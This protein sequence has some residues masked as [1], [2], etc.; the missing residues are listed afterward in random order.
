MP[1]PSPPRGATRRAR[2][3][4]ARGSRQTGPGGGGAPAPPVP[5][6][7]A[8]PPRRSWALLAL[9]AAAAVL[10]YSLPRW[11]APHPWSYDEYYHLGV[12]R[13]LVRH[14]PLRRFPW[15]PFSILADHYA[16]KEILFHL[17]LMPFAR[18]PLAAAGIAGTL[19]GQVFVVASFAFALVRLGVPRPHR[20]VWGLALLGPLF[21]YRFAMC[22]PQVWMIA[23]ALLFLALLLGRARG[24]ALALAAALFG[25]AHTG[26]WI[27]VAFAAL[28]GLA[29]FLTP[30]RSAAASN[31]DAATRR[32]LWRPLAWTAGGWLAGQLVHPNFPA[33]FRLAFLQNVVVP[34]QSTG[35]GNAALGAVTGA[36]LTAPGLAVL[37]EQWPAFLAPIA[38]WVLL[39]REPRLRTR[40]TLT[41]AILAAGFLALGAVFFQRLLEIGAPLGLLAFALAVAERE[42]QAPPPRRPAAGWG[43][44]AAAGAVL[45][46]GLWSFALVRAHGFGVSYPLEMARWLGANGRSGERVFTAQWGDSA[47]IFYAAPQLQSLVALDPVF[48]YAKDRGLFLAYVDLAMGRS[49]DP[50]PAIARRFGCRWVTV[51]RAPVFAGLTREL[52]RDPRARLAYVDPYY[53]VFRLDVP[54]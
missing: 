52:A 32:L 1:S 5:A 22:R 23:F 37:A 47:P 43:A 53:L 6:V 27:V 13:E 11:L 29:G 17:G 25:L 44:L 10:F 33:N 16:D 4:A 26:G 20:F 2:R 31:D 24:W 15:T 38:A 35:A 40:A 28:W 41:T 51:W 9:A 54:G 48:F 14:F 12:A 45:I 39:A 36:E 19:L 49:A 7:A 3:Q 21:A 18:L 34:F 30:P 50:V 8:P 46:G 42:R